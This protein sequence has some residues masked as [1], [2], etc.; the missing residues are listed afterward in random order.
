VR[1][2]DLGC[3]GTLTFFSAHAQ[4][5]IAK[6]SILTGHCTPTGTMTINQTTSDQLDVTYVP[7]IATYTAHAVLTRS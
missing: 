3:L 6:E 2:P 4:T 7:D 5:V 1:Y